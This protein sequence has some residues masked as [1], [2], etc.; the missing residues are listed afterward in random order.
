MTKWICTA[1]GCGDTKSLIA[2]H[3]FIDERNIRGCTQCRE[4]GKLVGACEV[5]DCWAEATN[6]D[7]VNGEYM[8][9]C[10]SHFIT[11]ERHVA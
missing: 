2:P 3:P 4:A 11:T 1:C 10:R 6:S 8:R 7:M 5:P 9:M